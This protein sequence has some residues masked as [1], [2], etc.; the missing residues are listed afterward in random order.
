MKL[1]HVSL[2]IIKD[3]DIYHG[4]INADFGQGFY[5]SL[6]IE[7]SKKWAP[8]S[9][10]KDTILNKDE[11]INYKKELEIKEKEYQD[12]VFLMLDKEVIDI[13]ND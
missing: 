8:I 3:I 5:S 7:F 9:K 11:I 2:D 13:L 12:K 10:D 4:R 6:N 1:Y